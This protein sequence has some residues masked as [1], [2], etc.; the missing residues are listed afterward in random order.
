[1]WNWF[2]A[3][4]RCPVEAQDKQWIDSRLDQLANL[5]GMEKL[6]TAPVI[7]PTPEHFPD[8]YQGEPADVEPLKERVCGYLGLDPALIDVEVYREALPQGEFYEQDM[9]VGCQFEQVGDRFRLLLDAAHLDT[10]LVVVALLARELALVELV[11]RQKL[12]LETHEQEG[13]AELYTVFLGLGV[14]TANASIFEKNWHEGDR[15]NSKMGFRGALTLA[16]Y[17]Y[18][19]ARFAWLRGEQNPAWAKQL[20]PDV[21]TPFKAALRYLQETVES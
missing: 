18:A 1:M 4:P 14:L 12:P 11:G 13:L 8:P 20:R 2:R 7:L 6:R 5:F 17:G 9:D 16:M 15:G 10:P 3:P 19:L 21:R